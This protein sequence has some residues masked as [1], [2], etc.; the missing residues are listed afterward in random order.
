MV[1][2]SP[3]EQ[4]GAEKERLFLIGLE[5]LSRK[6]GITIG[7][8]GCCG[9]PYLQEIEGADDARSGYGIGSQGQVIWI[10]PAD[11]YDWD[12]Y[13]DSIVKP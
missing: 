7:G 1:T 4:I 11:E 12:E 13:A 10:S 2:L 6:T 8:C 9:S 3:E 5:E